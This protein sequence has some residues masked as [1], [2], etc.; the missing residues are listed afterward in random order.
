AGGFRRSL[1]RRLADGAQWLRRI[2][3]WFPAIHWLPA[4]T[5]HHAKI[6][7]FPSPGQRW[8]LGPAPSLRD[9]MRLSERAAHFRHRCHSWLSELREVRPPKWVRKSRK[10]GR[11]RD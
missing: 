11:Q 9:G 7:C 1:D 2:L 10:V 8:K 4:L 5:F 3:R 6:R